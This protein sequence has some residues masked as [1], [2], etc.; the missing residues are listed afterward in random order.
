MLHFCKL[1]PISAGKA[2]SM[3]REFSGGWW[4]L[5]WQLH[6]TVGKGCIKQ[7]LTPLPADATRGP[8]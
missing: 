3:R 8:V 1:F 4:P 6:T 2:L 7:L 5:L